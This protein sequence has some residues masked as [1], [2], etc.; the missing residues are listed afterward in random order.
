MVAI[1][2]E[3]TGLD[4]KK[5][6]IIE[7][8]AVRFSGNVIEEEWSSLIN[9]GRPIPP[10]IIQLTGIHNEMVAQAPFIQEVYEDLV[11]FAGDMPLVGHNISFDLGFL[12]RRGGLAT[13]KPVDTYEMAAILLPTAERY[14]LGA[15][16]ERLG[17]EIPSAHR[18]LDDARATH[19]L[20]LQLFEIAQTLPVD[21]L[22]EILQ[23]SDGL[24]WDGLLPFKMALKAAAQQPV[25]ARRGSKNPAMGPIFERLSAP[26]AAP[27]RPRE[28]PLGL[29][30]DEVASILEHGG[31][32]S[33]HFPE[34]EYRPE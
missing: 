29:D 16:S 7:I 6:A 12:K 3:T 5:D 15:L 17:I 18:A 21:L 33:R 30:I 10:F 34:F 20:F 19:R 4:P 25:K 28:E 2:I 26:P 27:L 9:P 24:R 31:A 13:N 23:L 22:S 1:D 8:G 11:D 14:N 32:F